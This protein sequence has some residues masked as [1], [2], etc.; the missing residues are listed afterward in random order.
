MPLLKK[1][2]L[3]KDN[4]DIEKLATSIKEV[5]ITKHEHIYRQGSEADKIYFILDG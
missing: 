3:F 1:K 4:F 5:N 2:P